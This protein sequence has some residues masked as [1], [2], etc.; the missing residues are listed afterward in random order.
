MFIRKFVTGTFHSQLCSE[1]IIKRQF[2]H[3]RLAAIMRRGM[4]P[5]KFHFLI[6]YTEE[7]LS[8]WLQ[9]PITIELQTIAS[10]EE[11]VFKYI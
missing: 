4:P 6:G 10:P 1:I 5:R 8:T 2:N 3:I 9:C 7:M 11:T